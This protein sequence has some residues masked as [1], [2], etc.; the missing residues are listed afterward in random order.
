[1]MLNQIPRSRLDEVLFNALRA[2]YKFQQSKVAAYDLDYQ[3]IYLLQFLRNHSPAGMGEIARE[4]N[5]PVSTAT[6]T[7]D[8]LQ[9]MNLV[10][11]KKNARDKRNI[12]V[13]L[14][15]KGESAVRRIEDH[16]FRILSEN[17]KDYEYADIASFF[18]TAMNLEKILKVD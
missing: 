15:K 10:S 12:L 13:M 7:V 11:R 3:D 17:L 16:T 1:M 4:M 9:N 8:R 5:I 6:H 18:K 2:V 14:N